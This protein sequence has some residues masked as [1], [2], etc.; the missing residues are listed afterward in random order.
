MHRLTVPAL[1][2]LRDKLI[3]RLEDEDLSDE[4]RAELEEQL[5]QANAEVDKLWDVI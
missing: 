1:F 4:Q 3:T 2:K 5:K